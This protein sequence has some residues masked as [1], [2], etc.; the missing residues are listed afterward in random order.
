VHE[1]TGQRDMPDI[2]DPV[3]MVGAPLT[4]AVKLGDPSARKMWRHPGPAQ[5]ANFGLGR[6]LC[7][8]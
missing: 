6:L 3:I 2:I 7:G 4:S 8:L 1:R 5:L